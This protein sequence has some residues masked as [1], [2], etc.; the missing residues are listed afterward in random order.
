MSRPASG[1][2]N[3]L[4]GLEIPSE[5]GSLEPS[6]VRLN[7]QELQKALQGQKSPEQ[8]ARDMVALV[9]PILK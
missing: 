8:A 1:E 6:A 2:A 4:P 3:S 5:I 9:D 7:L